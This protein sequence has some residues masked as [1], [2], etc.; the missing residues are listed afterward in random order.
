MR[1]YPPVWLIARSV[2][3]E[4]E[5]GGYRIAK[6]GTAVVCQYVTH[7]HPDFWESPETFDPDRFS[8]ERSANRPKEAYFPFSGGPHQCI[9]NDFAML[10]MQ[11]V[12][13]RLMQEFDVSLVPGQTIKAKASVGLWPDGPVWATVSTLT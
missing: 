3:A 5:I 10:A 1:L 8:P 12:V 2:V 9:G 6:R 11:L 13:A 4:D 7:R